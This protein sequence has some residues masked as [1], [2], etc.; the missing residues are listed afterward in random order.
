[1]NSPSKRK[2]CQEHSPQDAGAEMG[3][4]VDGGVEPQDAASLARSLYRA[5]VCASRSRMASSVSVSDHV[6]TAALPGEYVL[7]SRSGGV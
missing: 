3:R 1:M 6:S 7:I 2:A 4:K 5:A